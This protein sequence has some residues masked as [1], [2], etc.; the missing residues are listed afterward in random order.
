MK[1]E[2]I[3]Q[4]DTARKALKYQDSRRER[5]AVGQFLTPPPIARYMAGL[6]Q[7]MP[8]HVR[9][10][11]PGAGAGALSAAFIEAVLH[12]G[13]KPHAI[14]VVAYEINER[15]LPELHETMEQCKRAC[16]ASGIAFHAEI[17]HRDFIEAALEQTEGSLFVPREERFTHAIL[18]PPYKKLNCQTATHRLLESAGMSV[19]NLYAAFVWL[20][21]RLLVDGGELAAITPRSF[22][23]GP[24]FRPF[25]VQ[26]LDMMNL[27]R[28]HVF[29]SRKK[30]FGDDSVLQENV[31]YSGKKGKHKAESVFISSSQGLD[32]ENAVIRTVPYDLVVFP[33]D[34]DRFI[35]LALN[36]SDEE[37]A[38]GAEAIN[39]TLFDIGLEVSTGRVVDFRARRHLLAAA[40]NGTVPL[41]YPCHFKD[42][43]VNWPNGQTKKPNGIAETE[44]TKDLLIPTGFYVLTKRFTS[45]EEKRRVVA[46]VFDPHEVKAGCVGFENHLNYFHEK[47]EGMPG[48][49]AK[50][51][52]LYL[53]STL[54][55][56]YFRLFSGHTQVNATDLRKMR[57]PSRDQL[58]R[59]GR[60][61]K[62]RMPGQ[63][64][65][66]EILK[67]ELGSDAQ[68]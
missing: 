45:K 31:I 29:E 7:R 13:R 27:A 58:T 16:E 49:L 12:R 2:L 14:E 46:A 1:P 10:L 39:K 37:V 28:I 33:G 5:A 65:I 56:R 35:H 32:F 67:K 59:L 63:D 66:D 4:A 41:I 61:V 53:N 24:Y 30:A 34:R 9:L 44:E 62:A 51:L 52:A 8:G 64:A 36:E 57:Y 48:N 40:G 47:G 68:G 23:N 17:R 6:F 3:S 42:G 54:F 25:R 20:S 18:N 15:I 11:D 60:H 43:F 55:D 50:G 22:C 26:F 21:A 38:K 19:S